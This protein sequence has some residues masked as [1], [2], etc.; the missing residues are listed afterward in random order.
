MRTLQQIPFHGISIPAYQDEHEKIWINTHAICQ[1]LGL[2]TETQIERLRR[3]PWATL[4]P[5]ATSQNIGD[6]F[7]ELCSFMMWLATI[8]NAWVR[9][10]TASALLTHLQVEAL[11]AVTTFMDEH[12]RDTPPDPAPKPKPQPQPSPPS[13]KIGPVI[14]PACGNLAWDEIVRRSNLCA[15]IIQTSKTLIAQVWADTNYKPD[16]IHAM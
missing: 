7:I 3:A 12:D 10:P 5:Q 16:F 11:D 6:V 13:P 15:T 9:N 1:A 8:N 14:T 4:Q 2:R